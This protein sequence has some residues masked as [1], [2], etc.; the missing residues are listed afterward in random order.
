MKTTFRQKLIAATC[1]GAL[2]LARAH[3]QQFPMPA[4]ADQVPGPAPGTAMTTAYVQ[5]AGRMA[6][7]WAWPLVNMANRADA[8]SKAPEPGL[9][10]GVVPV[11]FNRNAMLTG[12]VSPDQHFIACPNQDVVYG[13][14]FYTL[15]KEPIVFQV[16]DFG[17]RFWVYALYDARTDE[18]SAIG[19]ADGTKPGFYL[20]VGP[21]W[22]GQTPSGITAVVRS[23]TSLTFS[24]PRIFMDDTA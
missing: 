6:S 12:Y 9:L 22:K 4:T 1:F 10:G 15:D 23:S 2:A 8:F 13:A 7:L 21:G 3:A 20:M 11:A 17:D 18:F 5:M 19:K 24:V 16:P 14:G